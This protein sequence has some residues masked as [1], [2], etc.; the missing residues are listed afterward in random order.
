MRTQSIKVGYNFNYN[1]DALNN[2]PSLQ[3]M[4]FGKKFN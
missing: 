1:K 3:S 4:T 2:L